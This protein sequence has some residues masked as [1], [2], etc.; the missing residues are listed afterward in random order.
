[1]YHDGRFPNLIP[2]LSIM[3][4]AP[5]AP[6]AV[7][8]FARRARSTDLL[9]TDPFADRWQ[10]YNEFL[11]DGRHWAKHLPLTIDAIVSGCERR[12]DG[13]CNGNSDVA[14]AGSGLSAAAVHRAFLKQFGID[15]HDVP[16]I[17]W[18]GEVDTPFRI[19]GSAD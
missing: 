14:R 16:L 3:C 17:E 1:M 15:E 6:L 8:R 13:Q 19:A 7:T 4:P 10:V 18:T 12:P 11:V 9:A 2:V 5:H